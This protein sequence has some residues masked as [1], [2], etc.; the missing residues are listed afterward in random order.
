M[1]EVGKI[2][3]NKW[4]IVALFA[5]FYIGFNL[6]SLALQMY[7]GEI[8]GIPAVI[9]HINPIQ[10]LHYYNNWFYESYLQRG[11]T[12]P[13]AEQNSWLGM[14]ISG[15][16][17]FIPFALLFS[18]IN[19]LAQEDHFF[20]KIIVFIIVFFVCSIVYFLFGGWDAII[21]IIHREWGIGWEAL[22]IEA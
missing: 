13:L 15:I 19:S 18:F 20:G 9:R 4:V 10:Q 3:V 5:V 8:S 14:L 2:N 11:E 7:N 1:P 21:T 22:V 16:G 12:T 6:S 17:I